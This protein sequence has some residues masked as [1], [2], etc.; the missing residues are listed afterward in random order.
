[1]NHNVPMLLPY[2]TLRCE[3]IFIYMHKLRYLDIV[4]IHE[5]LRFHDCDQVASIDSEVDRKD[6]E[7]GEVWVW[8]QP[9]SLCRVDWSRM[10]M[11]MAMSKPRSRSPRLGYL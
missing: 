5:S 4:C 3:P 10:V 1:M 11:A 8:M 6:A 2:Q 9:R 7:I